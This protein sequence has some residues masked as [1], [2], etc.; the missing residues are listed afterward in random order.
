MRRVLEVL[1][2][3]C[4][5][6][7]SPITLLAA[8]WLG[9]LRRAGTHRTPVSRVLFQRIGVLPI[10]DHYYEPL[11]SL[12][13]LRKSVDEVRSLPGLDLNIDEQLSLLGTFSYEDELR[14]F[15]LT[16]TRERTYFYNNESFGSGDSEYLYS[17]IRHL[18][19][20]RIV[21]I[22]SGNSTLMAM[23]AV[24]RNQQED[25]AYTCDHVC[26]EPY[27]MPWLESTGIRVVR[28]VVEE[29]GLEPFGALG[30][31]DVLFIDSSHIIRPQG[32]VVF[33][34]LELL[35]QLAS[36]VVIHVHDIR[37]PRDV[38]REWLSQRL[39]LWNEQ[40]IL[41]ALLSCSPEFRIIGAVNYLKYNYFEAL[42]QRCPIL[43]QQQEREPGSFW[44]MR[45]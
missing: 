18:H 43:A 39:R 30:R 45:N 14:A 31:N 35:P 13:H 5:L 16:A 1:L 25:P 44:I 8:L 24:R 17:M 2:R 20:K 6:M 4:E 32:D 28:K 22:G 23:N 11:F 38:P 29:A 37:T 41:E 19:P 27:E 12:K 33:E 36:G 26:I 9:L 21:E 3:V 7:L 42:A 15:P 34:Y 40:Y 10:R